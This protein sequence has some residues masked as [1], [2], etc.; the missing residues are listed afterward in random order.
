MAA[1]VALAVLAAGACGSGADEPATASMGTLE[2]TS[3]KAAE[4]ARPTLSRTDDY[5]Q[6]N[7]E[8]GLT[9][10]LATTDLGVGN[11]R[12][13]FVLTEPGGLVKFPVVVVKSFFYPSGYEGEREGPV[14]E[15]FAAFREFPF[16]TR[17]V[18]ATDYNFD[19]SGEWGVE[20]SVPTSDGSFLTTEHRFVVNDATTAPDV[21]DRPPDALNR[22]LADVESIKELTTG[23]LRDP[24]LYDLSIPDA[25]ASDRPFAV[26]F[27]SPAFCTTAVCGP[28]VD[29]VSELNRAYGDRMDFIHVDLFINPHEIQGDLDIAV[30][31]PLLIKWGLYTD[32]W[33]F[34]VDA[35]GTVAGRF[36]GFSPFS[37]LE[38]TI[39]E[40]L[41]AG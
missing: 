33:T 1:S 28:Q 2:N 11:G 15:G 16:G 14:E 31:T 41:E 32:E 34:V 4:E 6:H 40:T 7:D 38:E 25:L 39:L 22:T 36:E 24:E 9:T 21:G 19:R 13:A 37:E 30:H 17:G 8:N 20:V 29:V 10:I 27:A 3:G 5:T 18:Y 23:S 12:F 26:V 35:S